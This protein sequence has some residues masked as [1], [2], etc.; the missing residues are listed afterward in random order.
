MVAPATSSKAG[1][2]DGWEVS[3]LSSTD[4]DARCAAA[5]DVIWAARGKWKYTPWRPP[6]VAS[7]AVCAGERGGLLERALT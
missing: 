7:E 6:D 3:F 2:A 1:T 5:K 4:Q